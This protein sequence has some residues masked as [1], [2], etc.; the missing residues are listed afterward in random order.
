M[1]DFVLIVLFIALFLSGI[2][3]IPDTNIAKIDKKVY[4]IDKIKDNTIWLISGNISKKQAKQMVKKAERFKKIDNNIN[5]IIVIE[6]HKDKDIVSSIIN[7]LL[8]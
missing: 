8:R 6:Q 7:D 4:T 1:S 2:Y 3:T 5:S